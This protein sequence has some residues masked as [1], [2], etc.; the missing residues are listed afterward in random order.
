MPE[1]EKYLD[2]PL[3]E[4]IG[5]RFG[6]YSKYIIQE[7]AL[8]DAR[9]GLKPVQRR[10]LYAMLKDNNTADKPFRKSAK[11]VGNVIGNYHP[12]GDSS[13]YEALVRMSQ[14]WKIRHGLVEMHG[15][16]GSIDGD[17]PAAMRYTEARISALAQEMLQDIGK[18]T[19]EFIPNF[20]DTAEEPVVLPAHFPSLL[21]NGST[22]ISSGYATDIP[23][24]NLGEVIDAAIQLLDHPD[25]PL[26]TLLSF[27][28]GPDFPGGGTIQGVKNLKQAYETGK[29]KIVLRGTA[30]IETLRGGREQIVIS[31]IPYEV[32]KA[33][34]V[35]RIDEIRFDKKIDGIAEVRDDTDRSG[36]QVVVELKKEADAQS[37][38]NYLY[39]NTDLQVTYNFNM[40]AI[41]EKA[42]QLLGLKSLLSAYIDH[43]KE[44]VI[45]RSRYE[46]DQATK[47]QHIVEGLM[48][49]ISVLDELISLIRQSNDK[50]DAK[51]NITQ[52]FGFTEAQAEAIVNLQLYRL[53][54]TDIE[55]LE[56]EAESLEQTIQHLNEIL[57]S[58]KKLVQTIK[59]GL[60]SIKKTYADERR[61]RIEDEIEELKIDLQVM[62]PS[63]EVFVT[64][65]RD[66]YVKRTSTRSYSASNDERPGMK[67]TDDLQF[68]QEMNTTET[69]LVFTSHGHYVYIPVHQL[70]DIRWKDNGQHIG[71]LVSLDQDDHIV[72]AIP[73]R[74][75]S[76]EQYL[77][78][79]TKNGIAKRSLLKD[80]QAQR[81]S[82]ALIAVKLKEKDTL[83]D[84]VLTD[85]THDIF[86]ATKQ[87]YGLRFAETDVNVVGLR[88]AGVKGI[89]LKDGDEVVSAFTA[90]QEEEGYLY[91]VSQRGAVKKMK[92]DQ[93]PKSSRSKRGLTMLREL[94]K[95]PHVLVDITKAT[96][97]DVLMLQTE[98]EVIHAISGKD[99]RN[100]DRY[101]TGSYVLDTDTHGAVKHMWRYVDHETTE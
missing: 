94:K 61:T 6:R 33:N 53:T 64:V 28:K 15:N 29:G 72:R 82:R 97:Q 101:Q 62:I 32:V 89:A 30:N 1:A 96:T 83:I 60:K 21:V 92:W 71:N 54:N 46:L 50:G 16:N 56:N 78:F 93:F 51:Q 84:V 12:H 68:F 5:D 40:V 48:K 57:N 18:G 4:V 86:F 63:E 37:I 13:V 25:S 74:S 75:F 23:P 80:Y 7:R 41:A 44:V 66:G 2:L 38:L 88:T 36:L 49:A 11:T 98:D 77:I 45:N 43:Q 8:P 52:A 35:K 26:E 90:S 20:D 85:G 79:F 59:K 27:I 87:G 95:N 22:G 42:P 58:P 14:A 3:E 47:R 65:S 39:K 31:E 55:T 17:P 24:H 91:S 81:S 100:Y 69:L 76:E 34:L 9:D 19:V 70:P 73:I 99:I 67:D 10:I